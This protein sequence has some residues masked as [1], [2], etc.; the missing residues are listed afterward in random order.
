MFLSQH[1]GYGISTD[2]D[3]FDLDLIHGFL[4]NSY[5][6][7]GTSREAVTQSIRHS[8][9]FGLFE[10]ES[11]AQVGFARVITD[12]TTFGYLADVFV[13]Q[14]H[15]GKGL[16]KWLIAEILAHP[17]LQGFRR[18]LLAT[19]DAH[20]IYAANGFGPLPKPGNIMQFVPAPR[21]E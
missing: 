5:W 10:I 9:C 18:W 7:Q 6:A 3:R 2:P 14:P 21:P 20:A 19:R 1:G 4:T 17:E 16:G 13:L 12:R 15:R 8:L 11:G